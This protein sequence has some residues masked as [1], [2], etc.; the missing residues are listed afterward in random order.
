MKHWNEKCFAIIDLMEEY[1]PETLYRLTVERNR[2]KDKETGRQLGN[3]RAVCK[4]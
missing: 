1:F 2:D 4:K 3:G